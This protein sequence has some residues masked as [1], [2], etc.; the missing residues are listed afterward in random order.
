MVTGGPWGTSEWECIQSAV[1]TVISNRSDVSN[2]LKSSFYF[3]F[4]SCSGTLGKSGE[5][6]S[7]PLSRI[8]CLE[9]GRE[10]G[11]EERWARSLLKHGWAL[12]DPSARRPR[13]S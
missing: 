7:L 5:N 2:L 13:L 6:V 4:L 9:Q 8:C 11:P 10:R 3:S 1:G 12:G